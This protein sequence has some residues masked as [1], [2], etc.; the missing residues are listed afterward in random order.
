MQTDRWRNE[1]KLDRA[2]SNFSLINDFSIRLQT[3]ELK[4]A[5]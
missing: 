2:L 1:C 3:E 4:K 5:Q